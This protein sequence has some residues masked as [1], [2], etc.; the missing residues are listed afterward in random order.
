M[1]NYPIC[2]VDSIDCSRASQRPTQKATTLPYTPPPG[3][4]YAPIT[5]PTASEIAQTLS[6]SALQGKQLWYITIPTS[7]P[8]SSITAVST[9]SFSTGAAILS[10]NGAEYGLIPET[11]DKTA[12]RMVLLPSSNT[13]EYECASVEIAKT[14]H[15]QQIISLPN[16]TNPNNGPDK[17][18]NDNSTRYSKRINQQ[19]PGLKMRYRPFGVSSEPSEYSDSEPIAK[20]PPQAAQFR[21]P[22]NVDSS[23][24]T[25]RKRDQI[26]QINGTE[27]P[28][29][30]KRKK[31]P[32]LKDP[33]QTHIQRPTH[34]QSLAESPGGHAQAEAE[35]NL[36][37]PATLS[38]H[39]P[40]DTPRPK[41]LKKTKPHHHQELDSPPR[42]PKSPP[43]PEL[44]PLPHSPLPVPNT[45][46]TPQPPKPSS[47]K[48]HK[49]TEA[50]SPSPGNEAPHDMKNIPIKEPQHAAI[51]H[52]DKIQQHAGRDEDHA[53]RTSKRNETA[54]EKARRKAERRKRKEE[55][56]KEGGA[57][58]ERGEGREE[59]RE[60][61]MR[62]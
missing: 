37:Y 48:T 12:Q 3:F 39:R 56:K 18:T 60:S 11:H 19:P 59:R 2:V 21:V 43:P 61:E 62:E 26:D 6:G 46:T 10:Y 8:V 28:A 47:K 35:A 51:I 54:E 32:D 34:S 44:A 4:E 57:V 9:R 36:H 55:G 1:R 22:R 23:S 58:G 27:S 14:L 33:E 15:L 25:K 41:S 50:L 5:L 49:N 7:V 29:K 45:Y 24:S 52:S 38:E 31:T 13:G 40:T 42:P 53:P 17:P 30:V 20:E 16:P